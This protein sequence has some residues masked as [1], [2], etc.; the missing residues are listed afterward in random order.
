MS[1]TW[2]GLTA[3]VLAVTFVVRNRARQEEWL[4]TVPV[5]RAR[6]ADSDSKGRANSLGVV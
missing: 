5:I 4:T 1:R 2:L 6:R 3:T